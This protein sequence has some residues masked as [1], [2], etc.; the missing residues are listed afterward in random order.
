M[1]TDEVVDFYQ[2]DA[3]LSAAEKKIRDT[4][5]A[6]VD[7]ECMPVIAEHFDKGTFPAKLIP[8]LAGLGLFG[9]HVDGYGCSQSNHTTYGLIC[10]E[11]GRCDSGL[12]AMFSVQNSLVMFPIYQFGSE[13][14]REK[15]LPELATGSSIGCF[16]LSEPGFGSNPAGMET[17]AQK[18]KG[19]FILN[20]KKMWITNGT[21]AKVAII[22][23]KYNEDIRGFLVETDSPGFRANPIRRKF[24]YRTAP[25]AMIDLKDC[26]IEENNILPNARGLKSIF[27]CLNFARY[28]VACGAVG[29]AVSCYQAAR[30]FALDREVFDRPIA[31]YQLVQDRLVRIMVEITK[32]QLINYHLGRLLDEHKAR[33]AQISLAKMNNVREAMKVARRARDIL[34]ARGI[35][36]DHQVIR[37]LC[38]LE[39]ISALEGTASMHT[40]VIGKEITGISAFT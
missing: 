25:T 9:V 39:A 19:R 3:L 7:K 24:S 1:A 20:G 26:T 23:A 17:R 29:S 27:E 16:G 14:Q 18:K 38:D 6:F 22:W 12:R 40:L 15:W 32:A 5:R 13:Q 30:K 21:M 36:A 2:T 4:V 37:H 35:L 31:G 28:G 33:P 11:L 34:G 8:K 10:Q